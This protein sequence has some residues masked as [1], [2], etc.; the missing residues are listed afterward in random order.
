MT[1]D[2]KTILNYSAIQ[3]IKRPSTQMETSDLQPYKK[4]KK[5]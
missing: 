2:T 3:N 5:E 1:S 4:L